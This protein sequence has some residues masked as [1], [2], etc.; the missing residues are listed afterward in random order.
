[1]D[2]KKEFRVEIRGHRASI[3]TNMVEFIYLGK[4]TLNS[5]DLVDLLFLC[6]EYLLPPLKQAIEHLFGTRL[7]PEIFFD[8]YMMAK[9]FDCVILK[10]SLIEFG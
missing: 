10:Q 3:V 5:N 7:S 4:T 8:V 6:Q 1:M 9:A 2:K